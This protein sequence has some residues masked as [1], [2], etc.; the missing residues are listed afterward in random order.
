MT[1]SKAVKVRRLWMAVPTRADRIK[2]SEVINARSDRL[3]SKEGTLE[4]RVLHSDWP[5]QITALA[6]GEDSLGRADR[7]PIP[8]HLI[9]ETA[10]N[11][12]FEPGAPQ[13]WDIEFS[14]LDDTPF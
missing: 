5:V 3:I 8:L 4:V 11:L 6:T 1:P 12:S 14:I 13:S 7:G 2:T 9:L 10:Q